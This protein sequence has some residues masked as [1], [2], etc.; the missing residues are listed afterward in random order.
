MGTAYYH[1]LDFFSNTMHSTKC[2]VLERGAKTT[3]I[4]LLE[5]SKNGALPGT[6]M[7]VRNKS[8]KIMG[9][10]GDERWKQYNYF[11]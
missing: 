6:I 5:C 2:E 10:C 8:V 9:E 1:W 3:K 11:D 4:R 7:R